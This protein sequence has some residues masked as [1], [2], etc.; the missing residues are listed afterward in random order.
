MRHWSQLATRNW[1]VKRVRTAG[2]VLAIALGTG[3][4]VWVT[5]CYESVRQTMLTWAGGYVGRSHITIQSPLGKYDTLPQRIVDK[6]GAIQGVKTVA[7][8]LTQRLLSATER[9]GVTSAPGTRW[10]TMADV[11]F[12]GIDLAH[13][14]EV[15]PDWPQR[16]SAGRMINEHDQLACVLEQSIADEQGVGVCDKL[17]VWGTG[18]PE[19]APTELDIV[20]LIRRER[21]ARFQ[22]GV[23]LLRLPVLQQISNKQALVNSIDVVLNKSAVADLGRIAGRIHAAIR[24]DVPNALVRSAASRLER[25]RLAQ[26]QQ[27]VVLV[28]LSCMALLSPHSTRT[29]AFWFV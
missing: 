28:L 13:E 15:R 25:I 26:D 11:D 24:G 18:V 2:A 6:I 21:I 14:F 17:L 22:K 1:R 16:L 19:D 27:Q 9:R 23:A 20:G 29:S 10:P 3:A 8:V 5:C 7:A 12:E 4:V